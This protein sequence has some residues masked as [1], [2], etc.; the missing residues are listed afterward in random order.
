MPHATQV[1]PVRS[2]VATA[3]AAERGMGDRPLARSRR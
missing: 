1:T 3:V 2:D